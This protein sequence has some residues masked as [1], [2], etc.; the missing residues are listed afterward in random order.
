MKVKSLNR[1]DN[2]EYNNVLKEKL[3]KFQ[4][5][6]SRDSVA[7]TLRDITKIWVNFLKKDKYYKK[8][9]FI[10]LNIGSRGG[11]KTAEVFKE[12]NLL[13]NNPK[14]VVQFWK[15]PSIIDKIE[16]YCPENRKDRF[17]SVDKL[18][19]IKQN[20][21]FVI[22]EGLIGANAKEALKKEMRNLVKFLSKS[23]HYNSIILIN[24]V[25]LG[26]L[27][28]F[29][30]MIDIVSYRRLSRSFLLNNTSKDGILK[31]YGEDLTMMKD[32]QSMLVSSYKRFQAIGLVS[33][34]YE[35]Y[36]PWFNDD[37]SMYQGSVS[38]DVVFD[39]N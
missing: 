30:N 3:L 34:K 15:L 18:M 26:V 13:L 25:S 23:R 4:H 38:A 16:K 19:D 8:N 5:F 33:M 29:R 35:T 11:G 2:Y 20:S 39:E 7:D 21:I 12:T 24:S 1:S 28:Q 6:L 27:L 10:K 32:W 36:C 31:K 37:I 22:D 14:R 9:S 17:E